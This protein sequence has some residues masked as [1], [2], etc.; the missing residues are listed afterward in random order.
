MTYRQSP[1]AVARVC[2]GEAL[3]N[4]HGTVSF[5]PLGCGTLVTA[6]IDGLPSSE[7]GFF[8]FHIHENGDCS[9]SGFPNTGGHYNPQNRE[10]PQHAG[11][12][13]PLLSCG[14]KA[15]LS[16]LTDHFCVRDIIGRA[17]VIHNCPDDFTTQPSGNAGNKIACGVIR[18]LG[19]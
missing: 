7:S 18:K 16:V 5:T 11:D 17:V 4:L 12:L 6:E 2:G 13:P 14:G 15:Y 9:G 3:P 8:A 19:C 1:A 10:H